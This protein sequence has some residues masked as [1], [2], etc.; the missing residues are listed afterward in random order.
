MKKLINTRKD[1]KL[2]IDFMKFMYKD[3]WEKAE[4]KINQIIDNYNNSCNELPTKE[5][6]V[7]NS[8]KEVINC[9][10]FCETLPCSYAEG[11]NDAMAKI[12]EEAKHIAKYI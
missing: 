8:M 6:V 9:T 1:K 4:T 11:Y 3:H 12:E 2:L 10:D 7:L 5:K